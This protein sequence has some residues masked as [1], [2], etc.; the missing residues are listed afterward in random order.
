MTFV[1]VSVVLETAINA[2]SLTIRQQAPMAIGETSQPTCPSPAT[3]HL[4]V[5][6]EE[7]HQR[8]GSTLLQHLPGPVTV[9]LLWL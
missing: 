8:K 7:R 9:L 1:L 3:E 2:K 4:G 5:G 6:Q